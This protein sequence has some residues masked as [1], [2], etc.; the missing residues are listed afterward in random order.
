MTSRKPYREALGKD[1]AL[2][3]IKKDMGSLL[4]TDVVK[5]CLKVFEQGFEFSKDS[6]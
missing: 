1:I 6:F 3:Q 4:D 5:A 2:K